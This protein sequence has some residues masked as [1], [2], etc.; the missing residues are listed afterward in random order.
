MTSPEIKEWNKIRSWVK[1]NC[2]FRQRVSW[3]A[4]SHFFAYLEVFPSGDCALVVGNNKKCFLDN[5]VVIHGLD[6]YEIPIRDLT[7]YYLV[8]DNPEKF[9]PPE[10]SAPVKIRHVENTAYYPLCII[11]DAWWRVK[12]V[13]ARVQKCEMRKVKNGKN[14]SNK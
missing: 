7:K 5:P 6:Q 3:T 10:G 14:S 11:A 9:E 1:R 2:H 8:L 12:D 13:V 4:P